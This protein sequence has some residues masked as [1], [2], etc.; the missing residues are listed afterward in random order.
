M[1]VAVPSLPQYAFMALCSVKSTGTTFTGKNLSDAFPIQNGLK[2]GN[3]SWP[4]F[5]T[6]FQ[7]MP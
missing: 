5:L 4:M 2:K 7:N 1:R 3:A 6:L